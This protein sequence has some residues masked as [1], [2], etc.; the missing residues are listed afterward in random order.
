VLGVFTPSSPITILTTTAG[1]SL[2]GALTLTGADAGLFSGVSVVGNN[3]VLSVGGAS[4]TGDY[5][6]NGIVDAGDYVIWRKT[7]NQSVTPGT[8]ADGNGNGTI[9][10]GDYTFWRTKF[11]SVVPGSG[12]S[13]AGS[14]VPE[15][16][17]ACL[18]MIA[19]VHFGVLR[20]RG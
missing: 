17:S 4:P 10:A 1:I 14:Q 12:S 5:N 2:T 7:L 18:F 6:H 19:L 3:L 20:A 15:P 11:G 13:L 16:G 8:G 9:D